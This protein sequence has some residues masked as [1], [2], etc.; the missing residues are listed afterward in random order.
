MSEKS[1]REKIAEQ[2]RD[3]AE[4]LEGEDDEA[5]QGDKALAQVISHLRQAAIEL[6]QAAA[7]VE[8]QTKAPGEEGVLAEEVLDVA[9]R[10]RDLSERRSL[11]QVADTG[12]L[13]PLPAQEAKAEEPAADST[14]Q[15][16]QRAAST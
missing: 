12:Q 11:D 16:E 4:A 14:K 10:V 9:H 7:L 3:A 8:G 5:D 13:R 1:F 6:K 2:L 15:A